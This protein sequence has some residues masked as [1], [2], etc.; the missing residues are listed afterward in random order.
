M[1]ERVKINELRKEFQELNNLQEKMLEL[2]KNEINNINDIFNLKKK[3]LIAQSEYNTE[4]AKLNNILDTYK[5]KINEGFITTKNTKDA[6]DKEIK[7][8]E[9]LVKI[10]EKNLK[11]QQRINNTL[12]LMK[13]NY[14]GIIKNADS[15]W[16]YLMESDKIIK[17]TALNLGLSGEK[18]EIL[19]TNFEQSAGFA[20]RLG[21]NLSDIGTIITSFADETGR[22]KLLTSEMLKDFVLIGKGTGLGVEE[23]A[24]L[25]GQLELM[26]LN[27]KA[28]ME[29][30]QGIVNTSEKMGINTTM[31]LKNI[32]NNFKALQKFT[33][34][35]GVAG[36]AKMA[37]YSAKF[38]I[39]ISQALDSAETAR[40]LEGAINMMAQL[41]VMGGE[42]AKADPFE[43]LY[44]SRNAPEEYTKKI[45]E[46]TKGMAQF[47]KTASGTFETFISPVDL[48]R[49]TVVSKTLGIDKVQLVEQAKRMAEI[50]RMRQQMIGT[51][52]TSAQK[53]IIEGLA[54]FDSKTG[55]FTVQIGQ[56]FKDISQVTAQEIKVIQQQSSSLE[57]RAQAAQTFD[58]TFKNTINELKAALLPLLKG[59]NGVLEQIR[60]FL[61]ALGDGINHLSKIT[62]NWVKIAG[63]IALLGTTK[64]IGPLTTILGNKL[65][66]TFYKNL[67]TTA[68][69]I[70]GGGKVK[71]IKGGGLSGLATGAGM[72]LAGLG[73]GE[74]INLASKG[75]EGIANA[76]SKLSPEQAKTLASIV[77]SLTLVTGIAAALAF[78]VALLGTTATA[79]SVG[80]LAFG[81]AIALIGVGIGAAA[82]GIG[83]MGSGLA[84]LVESG[85]GSGDS[86][87]KVAAGITAIQLAMAGGGLAT[88]FT[89]G[90]GIAA[91]AATMNSISKNAPA[92]A[93]VGDSFKNIATV[94]SGNKEQYNDIENLVK[95]IASL[96]GKK[97]SPLTDL[98]NLFKQPIKVEFANKE[99]SLVSNITL[100]VDGNKIA[101][102]IN[103]GGTGMIQLDGQKTGKLPP[104]TINKYS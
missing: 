63:G 56:G 41:Q 7:S 99:V 47:R 78:G 50:Q 19:R 38:K 21:A 67:K 81:G 53:Q 80:L 39:D 88:I 54:N 24:K 82:A 52:L 92:I 3:L 91:F 75:I 6:L 5:K 58:E 46:M 69:G 64:L 74:G 8:Q 9:N 93:L 17:Q 26:G 84:K 76:M 87:L 13:L 30:V 28:S 31:V 2:E 25:G 85:K 70:G 23:A 98:A 11:V 89:G 27:A 86:L 40:T 60:P 61:S 16:K 68:A 14:D 36:I 62:P 96:E 95:T 90:A 10:A 43:M 79:A 102:A 29:Y 32:S 12:S 42:F 77:S 73:V 34:Q 22:A 18:S 66:P 1:A 101:S 37:E 65:Q 71:G 45:N 55:R 94:L 59:V 20:A 83:F 44:L 57:K 15:L 48:D 35:S 100:N 104:K 33:F 103:I 72:G 4:Q 49:L 97:I 51:N